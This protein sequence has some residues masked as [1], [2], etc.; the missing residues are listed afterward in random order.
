MKFKSCRK[1]TVN[2]IWPL[3]KALNL[4]ILGP[5]LNAGSGQFEKKKKKIGKSPDFLTFS[6]IIT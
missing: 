5:S 3:F 2:K 6:K 4:Y 1:L